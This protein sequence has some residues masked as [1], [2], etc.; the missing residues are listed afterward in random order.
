MNKLVIFILA[1][2]LL[3]GGYFILVSK[4][5]KNEQMLPEKVDSTM[6]KDEKTKEAMMD[7]ETEDKVMET[8][9]IKTFEIGTGMFY[10]TETELRVKEGDTVKIVIRNEG[11]M[12]DWNLD[13]FNAS[14]AVVT[15]IGE[16]AE[17]VFVADKAGTFEYYC[18]IPTH[19]ENGMVGNLIVE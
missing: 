4:D 8:E 18:S 7:E 16:T 9:E 6:E 5:A 14:T 2:A 10:F 13:E 1:A 15:N 17:V 3:I 11:G 12:H 19:R